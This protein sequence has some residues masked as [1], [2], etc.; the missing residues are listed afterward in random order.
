MVQEA[1]HPFG[2]QS[3]PVHLI[4]IGLSGLHVRGQL[5]IFI[6]GLAKNAALAWRS[7]LAMKASYLL[8]QRFNL[9]V[10][11]SHVSEVRLFEGLNGLLDLQVRLRISFILEFLQSQRFL[12]NF[13]LLIYDLLFLLHKELFFL[14]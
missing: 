4:D 8:L 13:L 14:L 10:F 7:Y 1:S 2:N 6:D 5:E 3:H 11:L 9:F 12:L